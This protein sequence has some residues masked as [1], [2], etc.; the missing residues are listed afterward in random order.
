M[1]EAEATTKQIQVTDQLTV[2]QLAELLSIPVS[3]LISELFKN[4]VMATVNERL[5]FDTAQ[6]IV[7]EM[8]LDVELVRAQ[9]EEEPVRERTKNDS[10]TAQSRPP[11]VAMM[12]HVDHGKTSLLDAIRDGETVK[13]EAGGITQHLSAYQIEHNGRAITFI[14]TPGHEAFPALRQHSAR[15]TDVAVIV[16]AADEGIKPQT[17]EAVRFAKQAGVKLIVAANKMDKPD[18]DLNKLKQQLADN[19]LTPE[20]WSGETIVLPVSAT[21]K[22][23]LKE[24]LDMI[25]LVSDVEELKAEADGPAQGIIIESHQEKGRGPVAVALV[26]QGNLK[27]GN[28]VVAGGTYA[29][30]R[31]LESTT[32]KVLDEAGPSMPVLM[33]GFKNLPEFGEEFQAV[34]DEKAARQL[35]EQQAAA[36]K[37]VGNGAASSGSELLQVMNRT[38]KLSDFPIVLK[39]D[40]QG[41]LT[42]VIDSLKALDTDEVAI[43]IVSSGVGV[44]TENDVLTAASAGAIVYGFQVDLPTAVKRIAQRDKVPLRLYSVIYELLDDAKKEMESLLKPE[45]VEE[46]LGTVIIK[47]IFRITKTQAIIGGEVS[48]GRLSLPALARLKRGNELIA[49]NLEVVTLHRGPT[50]VTEVQQGELGGISLKTDNKLDV[51]EDDRLQLFSRQTVQRK[52]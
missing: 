38:Q 35:A 52:L 1:A 43:K 39:A 37:L 48:K 18:A 34:V 50:D 20:D 11:V 5:D 2:G 3:Q 15:L 17:L 12:G 33:T 8:D 29:K 47:G 16:V 14:D 28:F 7:G 31:N 9:A 19:D 22:T 27:A 41:S 6:I 13:G 45:V 30:V 36:K 25:L 49:D 40:V 26:E 21:K 24:L 23:G 42:S 10:K 4:G 51:V 44:L 46:E 32:G